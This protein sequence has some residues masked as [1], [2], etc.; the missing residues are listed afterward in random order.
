MAE[1]YQFWYY[2]IDVNN[3][4]K[5][6]LSYRFILLQFCCSLLFCWIKYYISIYNIHFSINNNDNKVLRKQLIVMKEYL[7]TC[8][9]ATEARMLLQLQNRQHFVENSDMYSMQDLMDVNSNVLLDELVV[10]VDAFRKHIKIECPVCFSFGCLFLSF[11]TIYFRDGLV[12]RVNSKWFCSFKTHSMLS[13]FST[14]NP[15]DLL[16]VLFNV[17]QV[18]VNFLIFFVEF[19]A[20]F[21]LLFLKILNLFL[22]LCDFNKRAF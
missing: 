13:S 4:R 3:Q 11:S 20:N 22:V 8:R 5:N 15:W 10:K 14:I 19:I 7:R 1:C 16:N 12:N 18:V 6:R 2:V 9:I 17:L 21:T